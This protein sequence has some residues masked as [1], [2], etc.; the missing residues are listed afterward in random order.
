MN[1][2]KAIVASI[3]ALRANATRSHDTIRAFGRVGLAGAIIDVARDLGYPHYCA[4]KR[5]R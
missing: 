3:R 5:G 1:D 2:R 4:I